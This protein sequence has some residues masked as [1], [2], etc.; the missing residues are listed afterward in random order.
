M[1]EIKA[2]RADRDYWFKRYEYVFNRYEAVQAK[3]EAAE[4][5]ERE[6]REA[7]RYAKRFLKP[8]VCDVVFIH[9]ALN[10]GETNG[11]G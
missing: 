3:L 5:R 10:K 7:L 9:G 8:D 1:N 2:L 4:A 6:L 11:Q